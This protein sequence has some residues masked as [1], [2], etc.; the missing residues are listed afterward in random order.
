MHR[1]IEATSVTGDFV[2]GVFILVLFF[3][4]GPLNETP[5]GSD[6]NRDK[7]NMRGKL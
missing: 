5:F 1:S 4:L 3:F 7:L 6:K 2:K